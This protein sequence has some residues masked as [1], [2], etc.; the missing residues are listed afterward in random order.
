MCN[1]ISVMQGEPGYVEDY[2]CYEVRL[3][4]IVLPN[5]KSADVLLGE[6]E[7]YKMNDDGLYAI[8]DGSLI[9]ET[10]LGVVKIKRIEGC[11]TR[12]DLKRKDYPNG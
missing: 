6:V 10:K 5:C 1:I 11:K 4:G 12:V 2:Y 9:T 8:K 7:C 3:D